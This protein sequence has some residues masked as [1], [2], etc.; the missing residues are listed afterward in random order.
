ML[1]K[2]KYPEGIKSTDVIPTYVT[3][4]DE[5]MTEKSKYMYEVYGKPIV[6]ITKD[7]DLITIEIDDNSIIKND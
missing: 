4:N 1:I 5:K 3:I 6:S 7:K 2:V